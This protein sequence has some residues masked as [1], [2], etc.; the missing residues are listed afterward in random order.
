M[1]QYA[2]IIKQARKEKG[3][4][5]KDLARMVH[6]SQQAIARYENQKAEPSLE[7]L[8]ALATAL[9]VPLGYF[10]NEHEHEAEQEY[11]TLYRSL[12][13]E[14]QVKILKLMKF[15]KQQENEYDSLLNQ[16]LKN[17]K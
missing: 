16:M 13:T 7:V 6:V 3:L 12:N 2:K 14:N 8:Q 17:K 10:I 4:T 15:L 5:Q 1:K 9:G 11:V